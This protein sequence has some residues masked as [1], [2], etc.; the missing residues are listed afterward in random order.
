M[1]RGKITKREVDAL[2]A[3]PQSYIVWDQELKGFGIK[4][5]KSGIKTYIMQYR[6]GFGRQAPTRRITLGRHGRLT[7]EAARKLAMRQFGAIAAGEDP[8]SERTE[9]RNAPTIADLAERFLREHVA[10]KTK[11]TTQYDYRRSLNK[12]I[13]PRIGQLRV[14]DVTRADIA[15]LHN[16]LS[17]APYG[18]NRA[19]GVLSK[20]FNLAEIWGLRQDGSNPCRHVQKFKERK[21]ERMLSAE[22]LVRLSHALDVFEGSPYVVAAIRL[23]IFTGARVGEILGL[24]WEW[25]DHERGCARL[26]DSKTGPKTLALP[27]QALA[28]LADIIH[29]DDNPYVIVGGSPSGRLINLEKPWRAIRN[30]AGLDDL[31]LHDLRHNFASVGAASGMGLYIIGKVLGHSQES[32]TARYA[33]LAFDPVREAASKIAQEIAETMVGGS[34]SNRLRLAARK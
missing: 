4:V 33:H 22:E 34:R 28:I 11:P 20:M 21:R 5:A 27:P 23:L 29:V 1:S 9:Q 3:A 6:A 14:R 7:P 24:K 26:P 19:V 25:V 17:A 31:R 32:T 18:A 8:A 16:E 13:L 15:H 10:S 12:N 2:A 30:A